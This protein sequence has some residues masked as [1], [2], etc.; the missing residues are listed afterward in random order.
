MRTLTLERLREIIS[1]LQICRQIG[2]PVILP[3]AA[4]V[5][6][7]R[8]QSKFIINFDAVTEEGDA[9]L[10]SAL[11]QGLS[12]HQTLSLLQKVRLSYSIQANQPPAVKGDY[13]IIVLGYIETQEREFKI[14]IISASKYDPNS[15]TAHSIIPK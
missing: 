4:V 13:M 1:N 2:V 6:C 15:L 10:R 5:P 3:A 14:G 9:I 12:H 8:E 7:P 11:E